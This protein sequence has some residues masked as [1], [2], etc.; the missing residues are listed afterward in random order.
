MKL[1]EVL[2]KGSQK[3]IICELSPLECCSFEVIINASISKS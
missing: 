1:I 2:A 3:A